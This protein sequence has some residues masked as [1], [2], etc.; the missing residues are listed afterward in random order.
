[1][2][3]LKGDYEAVQLAAVRKWSLVGRR[4]CGGTAF[5]YLSPS[6]SL[7]LGFLAAMWGQLSSAR[8]FHSVLPWSWLAVDQNHD[9]KYTSSP[10]G[11]GGRVLCPS[12]WQ[13]EL[14]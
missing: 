13:T 10:V 6:S 14:G 4:V 12:E 1:M 11:C 7:S 3:F 2:G 8:P 5:V 9:S